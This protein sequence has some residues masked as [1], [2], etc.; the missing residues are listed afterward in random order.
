METRP[1]KEVEKERIR[2]EKAHAAM[3]RRERKK[4]ITV[5]RN[6]RIKLGSSVYQTQIDAMKVNN[7]LAAKSKYFTPEQV[8]ECAF[9][10][11]NDSDGV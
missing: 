8:V 7:N 4:L 2:A 3:L 11:L 10:A 6:S 5:F 1:P 9:E